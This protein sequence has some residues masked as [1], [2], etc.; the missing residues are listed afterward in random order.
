[1]A[2]SPDIALIKFESLVGAEKYSEAAS[3]MEKAIENFPDQARFYSYLADLYKAQGDKKKAL[4][5]FCKG[6]ESG[7]REPIYPTFF[8]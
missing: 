4:E 1:M 2:P 8:S 6:H 7:A 5:I 3:V